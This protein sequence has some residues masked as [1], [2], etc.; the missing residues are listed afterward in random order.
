MKLEEIIHRLNEIYHKSLKSPLT[1]AELEE[2][3]RLRRI[4]LD[5]I[6]GQVKSTLE[7][8]KI[9]DQAQANLRHNESHLCHEHCTC[10]N[11]N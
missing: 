5:S 10:K 7:R 1:S 11:K 2:R 8:V 9:V 3:N 4:Y 6:R